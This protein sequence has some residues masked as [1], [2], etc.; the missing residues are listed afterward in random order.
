V[1]VAYGVNDAAQKAEEI[2][3]EVQNTFYYTSGIIHLNTVVIL[4]PEILC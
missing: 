3:S 2:I 1:V 4:R